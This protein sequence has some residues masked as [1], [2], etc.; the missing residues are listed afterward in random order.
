MKILNRKSVSPPATHLFKK[1]FILP[2]LFLIFLIP[3][4]SRGGNQN[5]LKEGVGVGESKISWIKI[6]CPYPLTYSLTFR[7]IPDPVEGLSLL[8]GGNSKVTNQDLRCFMNTPG[9]STSFIGDTRNLIFSWKN[10]MPFHFYRYPPLENVM[11]IFTKFFASFSF[12]KMKIDSFSNA[13]RKLAK[14]TVSEAA[15]QRCS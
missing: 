7:D 12:H 11:K 2:Q 3:H 14:W 6:F 10:V 8:V 15:V 1:T 5:L 13:T 4:L 9:N